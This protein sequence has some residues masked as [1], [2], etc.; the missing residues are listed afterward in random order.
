MVNLTFT[1][2]SKVFVTLSSIA[3]TVK[4]KKLNINASNTVTT[5]LPAHV[6]VKGGIS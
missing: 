4:V 1:F 2:C 5:A 3:C 6:G